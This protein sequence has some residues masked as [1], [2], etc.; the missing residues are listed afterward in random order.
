MVA[1]SATEIKVDPAVSRGMFGLLTSKD[2][3]E[4]I[5]ESSSAGMESTTTTEQRTNF[6]IDLYETKLH[7][8]A[9]Y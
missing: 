9:I 6:P 1:R 4:D 2:A 3:S 8:Q 5:K 7:C